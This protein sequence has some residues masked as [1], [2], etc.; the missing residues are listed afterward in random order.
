MADVITS[1]GKGFL[2]AHPQS[3]QVVKTLMAIKYC[4]TPALGGHKYRCT[5]CE[6]ERFSWHS[7]RNRHCPKCQ[8]INREKWIW[9]REQELLPVP[10]FHI[11]FTL[12]HELNKIAIS[13]PREVYNSL[14]RASWQTIDTFSQDPKHL[15]ADTGMTAVLHT[16]GQNLS[17]HPH[18]HCIVPGGGIMKSG[19]WKKARNKGKYLFP[20][21][22]LALVFRA[23]FMNELRGT[24]VKVEQAVASELFQKKWIVYAK[25]PFLGPKQVVE[26]LGRYTHKIAISNHRIQQIDN[27]G[28]V[29]FS[30]KN[31]RNG[32]KKGVMTL[33]A[34]EFLRRF[35]MHILSSG[36]VRIRHY[37][38]LSSR[39]KKEKLN[40]ARCYFSMEQWTKPEKENWKIVAI[41]RLNFIPDQCP[42]C[43]E[44]SEEHTSELQS[45]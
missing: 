38:F 5:C 22:A 20:S 41:Q 1:Y 6:K 13:N 23:K 33:S 40:Q 30:W 10:Y 27:N 12:P 7:C 15:G 24:G 2:E 32:G 25:Q 45:H 37:G 14:F 16:W 35:C 17:L 28:T 39:N 43:K 26:Y 9:H 11:V 19:K 8:T 36:F 3:V 34:N 29:H 44:R 18:L 21:K 42:F 4:R 31:Y